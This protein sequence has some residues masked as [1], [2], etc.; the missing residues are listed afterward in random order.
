MQEK[1]E[2]YNN[3]YKILPKY[4]MEPPSQKN[5]GISNEEEKKSYNSNRS[6][7]H[8]TNSERLSNL[9]DSCFAKFILKQHLI[10]SI[11]KKHENL[12]TNEKNKNVCNKSE[13][14]EGRN[15]MMFGTY[16][17]FLSFLNLITAKY[18]SFMRCTASGV[19]GVCVKLETV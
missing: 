18:K 8:A 12:L 15:T 9:L 1:N 17:L 19:A 5:F 4:E 6:V 10:P 14:V 16:F 2:H 11:E 13:M 3:V 7:Q